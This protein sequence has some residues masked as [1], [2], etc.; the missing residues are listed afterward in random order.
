MT[1]LK[2]KV[3]KTIENFDS[4]GT[5]FSLNY[6]DSPSFNT[7]VGGCLS[8]FCSFISIVVLVYLL[9]QFIDPTN[10]ELTISEITSPKFPTYNIYDYK[11]LFFFVHAN[12]NRVM[13][14]GKGEDFQNFFT[15]IAKAKHTYIDYSLDPPVLTHEITT[16]QHKNCTEVDPAIFDTF[17]V[18]ETIKFWVLRGGIC[19]DIIDSKKFL[20]GGTALE[21]NLRS[22]QIYVYPC[23]L[24]NPSQC[25][26]PSQLKDLQIYWNEA[27]TVFDHKNSQNPIRMHSQTNIP[28]DIDRFQTHIARFK[29]RK[30][31]VIDNVWDFLPQFERGA[32]MEFESSSTSTIFRENKIP[33]HCELSDLLADQTQCTAFYMIDLIASPKIETIERKY[34]SII[35]IISDVGGFY[36]AALVLGSLIYSWYNSRSLKNYLR[37]VIIKRDPTDFKKLCS[38]IDQKQ[39][40]STIDEVIDSRQS[41]SKLF[42]MIGFFEILEELVFEEYHIT[43]LPL[44][45]IKKGEAKKLKELEVAQGISKDK[46][47]KILD[48]KK[49]SKKVDQDKEDVKDLKESITKLKESRSEDPL[50]RRIDRLFIRYIQGEEQKWCDEFEALSSGNGTHLRNRNVKYGKGGEDEAEGREGSIVQRKSTRKIEYESIVNGNEKKIKN[51]QVFPKIEEKV[52]GEDDQYNGYEYV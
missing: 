15:V 36:Q 34:T 5:P 18:T 28:I 35:Q 4:M 37:S 27:I 22:I 44:I 17:A 42:E 21:N 7:F 2:Q 47:T 24:S 41:A 50:T 13:L 26:V 8:I 25:A 1:N 16:Y 38:K 30:T 19:P 52:D 3:K 48:F 14:K 12:A 9:I 40:N 6:I 23:S 11:K 32:F 45:Q 39:L 33:L 31:V 49:K 43:L 29:V 46:S 10:V 51:S 20:V